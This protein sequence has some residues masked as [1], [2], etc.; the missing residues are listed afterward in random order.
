[1]TPWVPQETGGLCNRQRNDASR[2]I[3]G[4]FSLSEARSQLED[5]SPG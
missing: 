2:M 3:K 1:M 4:D 5:M